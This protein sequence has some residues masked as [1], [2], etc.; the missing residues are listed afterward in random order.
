MD[1]HP[2]PRIDKIPVKGGIGAIFTIGTVLS[3]IFG[4]PGGHWF[5]LLAIAL[6]TFIGCGL[7]IWHKHKPI[8]IDEIDADLR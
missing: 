6:G 7:F 8:E 4:I 2:G 1:W 3:F 5:A